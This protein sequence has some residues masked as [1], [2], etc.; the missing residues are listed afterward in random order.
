M[1]NENPESVVLSGGG[2]SGSYFFDQIHFHW[3]SEH[4]IDETRYGLE[5]HAVHHNSQWKDLTQASDHKKGIAV[6]GV[7]FSVTDYTNPIIE[8]IIHSAL[9]VKD[10]VG[11]VAPLKKPL[12][13]KDLM[14]TNRTTYFRYEGSLTTPSCGEAVIWTVFPDVIPISADQVDQLKSMIK[15]GNDTLASNYRKLQPLNARTLIFVTDDNGYSGNSDGGAR[16]LSAISSLVSTAFFIGISFF[17]K[18]F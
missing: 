17:L 13:L 14:P 16:S 10:K 8:N 15:M 4:T 5:M 9:V 2:L 1:N 3:A 7:L 6:L 12:S 18:H 11:G